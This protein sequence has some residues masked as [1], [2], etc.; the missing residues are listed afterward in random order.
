[1]SS[2]DYASYLI[3]VR[4]VSAIPTIQI[5]NLTASTIAAYP[6]RTMRMGT[7]QIPMCLIQTIPTKLKM[8]MK[9]RLHLLRQTGA[10]LAPYSAI[11][12]HP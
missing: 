3:E 2:V 5:I 9:K 12:T 11:I 4:W 6:T 7:I 8:E 10:H 1:M